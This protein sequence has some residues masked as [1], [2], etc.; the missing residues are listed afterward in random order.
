MN[1]N[2]FN[3]SYQRDFNRHLAICGYPDSEW[4]YIWLDGEKIPIL[5]RDLYAVLNTLIDEDKIEQE[6]ITEYMSRAKGLYEL[7]SHDFQI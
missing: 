7:V 3:E 1:V 2:V 6:I 4:A 5:K